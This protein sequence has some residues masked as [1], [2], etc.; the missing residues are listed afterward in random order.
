MGVKQAI[1]K[2]LRRE[3]HRAVITHSWI[4]VPK[5]DGTISFFS[6]KEDQPPLTVTRLR[7]GWYKLEIAIESR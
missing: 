4:A 1:S 5:K 6:L 7:S 2:L 3:A